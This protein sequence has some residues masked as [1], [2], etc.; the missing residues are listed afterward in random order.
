[1]NPDMNRESESSYP[2]EIRQLAEAVQAR[3]GRALLVGGLARD[4]VLGRPS[5][6]Y[7]L[8]IHGLPVREVA[9]AAGALGQVKEVGRSFGVF[10]LRVGDRDVDV[11][12]PRRDSKTGAG[13]RGFSIDVDPTMTPTE[14]ARRR[15]FTMNAMMKDVLTG[16][17]I[18]P[19][20]GQ[21]D[22]HQR[23][24]RLVDPAT[25]RDDPLRVLRAVQF[26]GR[27]GLAVEAKT[28]E[29]LR[30]MVPSLAEL[31]KERLYDEWFKLF[32][33][34]DQPS[35]GLQAAKDVGLFE[36]YFPTIER[37]AATP[38][39]PEFHP[40]GD[41]W[42]HTKLVVDQARRLTA[43]QSDNERLIIALAAFTHDLGKVSTTE[44][45][46]GRIRSRDHERAGAEPTREFLERSG[47]P[48][49]V[50]RKVL[51]LV[52]E[53]LK[54]ALLYHSELRGQWVSGGALRRLARRVYPATIEQLA[55]VATAD[56]LGRGPFPQPDGTAA[57]PTSDQA[58]EWLL[59]EATQRRLH[60]G[61]PEPVLYGR[62]LVERGWSPGPIFG[63]AIRLAEGL[64][65]HGRSKEC[66]LELIDDAADPTNA[67]AALTSELETAKGQL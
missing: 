34:A 50:I 1:M 59:R 57:W 25:F 46:D 29:T 65:E 14:A 49:G 21:E 61:K 44:R 12:L 6:D 15:D 35:L 23:R 9:E 33:R 36:R 22:L 40:E 3:G 5:K 55:T 64:A 48:E 58:S 17:L 27:F 39:E 42:T 67:I 2:A 52:T 31:P 53:H 37:L 47:F 20:H 41:V 28:L 26:V 13:H 19:F 24:L 38:Q 45:I 10:K 43:D 66:I 30:D 11:S 4:E 32:A 51:P 62:D 63:Q 18:D 8:E 7:D 54:P 60:E 16:E 56:H